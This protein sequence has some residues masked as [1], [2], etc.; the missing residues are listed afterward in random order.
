[1]E[2]SS[3]FDPL[4][5]LMTAQASRPRELDDLDLRTLTPFQRA[6]LVLDGTVTKLIEA[7]TLEPLD[8]VRLSQEQHRL[9]QYHSWL[10]AP[11]GTTVAL[12]QV[13]VRGRYSETFYTYAVSLLVLDRLSEHVR[14]GV[15]RQGEGIG[16]LLNDT[17]LETRREV[18]WCG[19]EHLQDLPEAVSEVSDGHFISRAY[20][21]IANGQP[22]AM[23]NEKFPAAPDNWPS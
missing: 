19:R 18:L 11:Q 12:R 8:I 9:E 16:R 1:M 17:A 7:Y 14:D 20:R 6:L 13:L 4:A 21:I 10:D 23:I 22:V 5:G 15:E 3:P 2:T